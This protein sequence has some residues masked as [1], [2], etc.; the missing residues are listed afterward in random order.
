MGVPGQRPAFRRQWLPM[1]E[2]AGSDVGVNGLIAAGLD[3]RLTPVARV[4]RHHIRQCA[5]CG[6][7]AL[8]HGQ[9]VLDIRRLVAHPNR[10]D[11]LV[12]TVHRR[13]AV[14]ALKIPPA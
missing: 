7:D 4:H 14:V 9:Q 1:W 5:G 3:G 8:Q 13:L 12:V 11:N 2:P 6:R 10:H